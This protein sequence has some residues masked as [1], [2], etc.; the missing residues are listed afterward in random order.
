MTVVPAPRN[1]K[2][3]EREFTRESLGYSE[4]L[5][6]AEQNTNKNPYFHLRDGCQKKTSIM[7]VCTVHVCM[8]LKELI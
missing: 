6:Q 5:S 1:R 3:E 2:Q 8:G 4:T 7:H